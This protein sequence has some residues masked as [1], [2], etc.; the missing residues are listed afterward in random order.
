MI[1]NKDDAAV[2][3]LCEQYFPGVFG[4]EVG[5]RDGVP[6]KPAPDVVERLLADLGIAKSEAVYIGDTEVDVATAINAGIDC[7]AVTW[8]FRDAEELIQSGARVLADDTAALRALL[9]A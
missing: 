9:L 3:I 8:G 7:V 1:S 6:L 5:R 2:K 4:Y